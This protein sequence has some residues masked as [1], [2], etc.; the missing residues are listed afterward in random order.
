MTEVL[1]LKWLRA[2]HQP[3]YGDEAENTLIIQEF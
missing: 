1:A 2:I 3:S